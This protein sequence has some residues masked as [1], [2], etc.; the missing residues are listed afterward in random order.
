MRHVLL[1]LFVSIHCFSIEFDR[2]IGS[3]FMVPACPARGE[4]H[5]KD[6]ADLYAK[7][8]FGGVILKAGTFQESKD[9]IQFLKGLGDILIAV[10]AE[11][12][13]GQRV[14][15]IRPFPK[16]MTLGAIDD[17]ELIVQLGREIGAQCKEL[18]ATMN[19]APVIDVNSNPKNPIIHMR[20]FGDDAGRVIAHGK[21][22]AKGMMEEGIIPCVKHFPGHGD[23][24]VDSHLDLPVVTNLEG[25]QPF[26]ELVDWGIPAVMTAHLLV[27]EIDDL[28]ASLSR[29][30]IHGILREKW[31]YEGLVI[32]D[33]LNMRALANHY[34]PEEIAILAL[35]AGTD[36]LLYGDHI[37]PNVDEIL[38]EIV[39]RAFKAVKENYLRKE[40]YRKALTAIGDVPKITGPV[41]FREMG[42]KD[43]LRPYLE[44]DEEADVCIVSVTEWEEIDVPEGKEIVYCVFT[45]PYILPKLMS[46]SIL[47]GYENERE[48]VEAMR[49]VLFGSL[50][51]EGILPIFLD[52]EI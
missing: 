29:K 9:L 38:R 33:A 44:I 8:P 19:F 42:T 2:E 47:I 10:D 13:L 40:L 18:G 35:E 27:L 14:T 17:D 7:V 1:F 20:A 41:A 45:S 3:H 43:L 24:D 21:A 34:T 23:V 12:G 11:T 15:D 22:L 36:I 49:G 32:S 52:S 30:I 5:R 39:P 46:G 50:K 31:G 48:V 6:L 51:A 16:H 25:L 37:D 4:E 28:P 26:K